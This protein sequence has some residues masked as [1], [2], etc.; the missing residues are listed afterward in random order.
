M[1][2]FEKIK[3]ICKWT[4][5]DIYWHF[6]RYC[7]SFL[8]IL[9]TV[10]FILVA[11]SVTEKSPIIFFKISERTSGQYDSILLSA[12]SSME[13][14][15][16]HYNDTGY[17]LNFTQIKEVIAD[18]DIDYKLAPRVQNCNVR[19]IAQWNK[20]NM[21]LLLMDTDLEKSIGLGT[22]YPF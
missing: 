7:I 13:Q 4:F 17:Y 8:T 18:D 1:K 22:E 19:P 5:R 20:G 16:N 3:F 14:G 21:C 2:L 11:I 6:C 15:F 10:L 9:L 12:S